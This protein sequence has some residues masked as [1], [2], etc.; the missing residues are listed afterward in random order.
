MKANLAI[1]MR[2]IEKGVSG[3]GM[4]LHRLLRAFV[5]Q[6]S[7]FDLIFLHHTD[8]VIDLYDHGRAIKISRNPFR[9]AWELRKHR[10][11]IIHYSPLS[12]FSPMAVRARFRCATLHPDDELIIPK[13]FSLLRRLH[14]RHFVKIYARMMDRIFTVSR[15][16][17]GLIREC[18]GISTNRIFLTPNA[19]DDK[20]RVLPDSEAQAAAKRIVGGGRFVLHLSNFSERKNP[21]TLLAG[22]GRLASQPAFRDL[23]FVIVGNGWRGNSAVDR[24]LKE[25]GLA[26]RV[27]LTGFIEEEDIPRLMNAAEVF[28][29]PSLSEGFGMPNLE[30]MACGCPV[31]TSDAFAIPEIVGEGALILKDK[32]DHLELAARIEDILS[33]EALRAKL[34]ARG[35]ARVADFSWEQSARVLLE[36]YRSLLA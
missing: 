19:V 11:D 17:A 16:S 7:D 3:S 15:T 32:T 25:N 13:Q 9:A 36:G 23:T 6:A 10:F 29:F 24:A 20:Y 31:I 21:W 5:R 26:D 12:A 35:L 18:Y 14:S 2:P 34:R 33:D 30:A 1:T 28:V 4:H 8:R 22:W 27:R